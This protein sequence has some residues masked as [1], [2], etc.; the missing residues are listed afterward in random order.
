MIENPELTLKILKYF[1]RDD[2]TWPANLTVEDLLAELPRESRDSLAYHIYCAE[3]AELLDCQIIRTKVLDGSDI[4]IGNIV[5]LTQKGG[6]YVSN[7]Q[8]QY[9][10]LAI[11]QLINAGVGLSTK[12]LGLVTEKLIK[13]ALSL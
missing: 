3:E 11:D 13:S 1:A 8:T 7:S 2:V 9:R 10:A 12:I 4:Q 6:E 5:G